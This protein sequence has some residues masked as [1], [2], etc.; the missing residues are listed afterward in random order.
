MS[1]IAKT[2]ELASYIKPL[3]EV[4][5]TRLLQQLSQIYNTIK[6]DMLAKLVTFP[7]PYNYSAAD[8]EK[9]IMKACKKREL[10]I[11]IDHQNKSLTFETDLFATSKKTI[12]EGPRLQVLTII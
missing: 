6:L 9:F 7:A 4:I 11:T 12:V 1:K 10:S 5:L 3:Y 2:H 8:I